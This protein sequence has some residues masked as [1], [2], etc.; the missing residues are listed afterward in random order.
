MTLGVRVLLF[1]FGLLLFVMIFDL[2]RRNRFR[3]ELSIG[4]L[5][6]GGASMFTAFADLIIDPIAFRLGVR[7]PPALAFVILVVLP[8]FVVLYFSVVVSDLKSQNKEL[9]QKMALMEY[10]LLELS[11]E[12]KADP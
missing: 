4:W 11:K 9:S 1:L 10:K 3:E 8:V 12:R 7:Y 2:V 6:V 5:L